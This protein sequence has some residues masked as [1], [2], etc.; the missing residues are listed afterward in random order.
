MEQQQYNSTLKAAPYT[1]SGRDVIVVPGF[2]NNRHPF[3][4]KEFQEERERAETRVNIPTESKN[5]PTM[6]TQAETN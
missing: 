6:K 4:R 1:S 2:Y 3:M 5:Q